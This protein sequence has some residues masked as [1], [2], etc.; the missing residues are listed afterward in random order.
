M[1]LAS[2]IAM[3]VTAAL[4]G[5]AP[6]ARAQTSEESV[7][8]T[9]VS[10]FISFVTW[11]PIEGDAANAPVTLCV[12]GA[13]PFANELERVVSDQRINGRPFDVRRIAEPA[14][15]ARCNAVYVVGA[16]V[17]D[18]LRAV[19]GRP[20]LTITDGAAGDD[21]RGIIHFVIVDRRVRF[22]IDDARAAEGGLFMSSRLLSL[23]VSVRR[24]PAS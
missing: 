15:A 2:A 20:V 3:L 8:A 6:P 21:A 1:R 11:P 17:E 14:S 4:M 5:A 13:E 9:F 22:H 23:G 10:R 18:T 7:K 19:R 24:R 12:I 16:R